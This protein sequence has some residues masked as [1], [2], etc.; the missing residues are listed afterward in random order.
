[1]PD[2]ESILNYKQARTI[3]RKYVADHSKDAF[4]GLL[5]VLD[6]LLKGVDV[7]AMTVEDMVRHAL[8][9]MVMQ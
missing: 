2:Q 5:P 4:G 1:M 8:K 9:A 3:G 6:E 7:I